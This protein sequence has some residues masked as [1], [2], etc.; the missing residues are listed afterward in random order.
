MGSLLPMYEFE[1]KEE[2]E[3]KSPVSVVPEI[4]AKEKRQKLKN[5]QTVAPGTASNGFEKLRRG[6]SAMKGVSQII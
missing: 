6:S 1:E 2:E 5:M 3:E 4:T